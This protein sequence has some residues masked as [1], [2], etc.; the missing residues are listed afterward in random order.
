[1][2]VDKESQKKLYG[3][4]VCVVAMYWM[5]VDAKSS[6]P[7]KYYVPVLYACIEWM[8]TKS[9]TI[10]LNIMFLSCMHVLNEW[11]WTKSPKT[12]L[13]V[14]LSVLCQC[15]EWMWTKSPTMPLIFMFLSCM[16]V[17]DVLFV[18][19][20]SMWKVCAFNICNIPFLS[21]FWMNVAKK[22]KTKLKFNFVCGA[23]M[24]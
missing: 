20:A 2:N 13:R 17:L 12:N 18:C 22:R 19:G 23:Y 16:H 11:R 14:Y 15:I 7:F 5:N 8:W 4:F 24:G 21:N 1:M 6:N 9:P 3:S 10:P